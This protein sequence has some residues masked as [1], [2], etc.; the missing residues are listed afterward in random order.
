[1]KKKIKIIGVVIIFII[2]LIIGGFVILNKRNIHSDIPKNYIA[3]FHGG[4]GEQTYETYIYKIDNG[5]PNYGFQYINVTSTT[6][7]YGSS[8]QISKI[9]GRGQFDWT[10]GAFGVAKR[11]GAYSYVTL[12]NGNKEYTIEEF[13]RMFLMD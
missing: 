12:P 3:I 11:N 6:E 4:S 13:Q 9:T 7:S 2:L 5:Q 8:N 1:M 10:D